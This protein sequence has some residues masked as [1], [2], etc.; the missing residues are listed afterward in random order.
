MMVTSM[1]RLDYLTYITCACTDHK[2]NIIMTTEETGLGLSL[3]RL[4]RDC[5]GLCNAKTMSKV[6]FSFFMAKLVENM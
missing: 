2:Y 5:L 4:F 1:F 3:L 6:S